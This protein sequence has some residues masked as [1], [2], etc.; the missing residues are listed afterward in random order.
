MGYSSHAINISDFERISCKT[1]IIDIMCILPAMARDEH[2]DVGGVNEQRGCCASSSEM[3]QNHCQE[4]LPKQKVNR[5]HNIH[6]IIE[7]SK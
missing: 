2:G 6:F 4:Q 3:L 1:R 5:S 7:K